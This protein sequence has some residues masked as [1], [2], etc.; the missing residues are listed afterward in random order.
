M[1]HSTQSSEQMKQS[2]ILASRG[3]T[4]ALW[5]ANYV[6]ELIRKLGADVSIQT[7]KTTGDI[8]QDRFLHEIGGKGLFIKE[9]EEAMSKGAAHL[10]VHS[11]KDMPA[12]IPSGFSLAAVL[13]R[14]ESADVIVFRS[15]IAEKHGL[16]HRQVLN[17]QNLRKLGPL[18][19]A[20]SSLRRQAILKADCPEIKTIPIRGN[21]DTRLKKLESEVTWDGII[22]AEASLER[23]GLTSLP[24]FRLDPSWFIPCAGQGALAIETLADGPALALASKL[25]CSQTRLAVDI[26]RSV[27]ARLGGDCTMPFGCLVTMDSEAQQ[28]LMARAI[29]LAADGASLARAECKISITTTNLAKVAE[30]TLI[31]GLRKNGANDVLASLGLQVRI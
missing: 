30:D 27:L 6:A 8:V 26:E 16:A 21:V 23:L 15:G 29:V 22:L 3:S 12:K 28:H 19:L 10:A 7:W 5:Q 2:F 4:L 18:T 14:H 20:T 1:T 13:K 9:L 24:A 31:E 17:A 11:L 25:Q